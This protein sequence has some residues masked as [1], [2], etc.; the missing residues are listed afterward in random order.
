MAAC[1]R[2]VEETQVSI[3]VATFVGEKG[4]QKGNLRTSVS[5]VALLVE[6]ADGHLG[7]FGKPVLLLSHGAAG[8]GGCRNQQT[9]VAVSFQPF[10]LA[11]E[12]H[13]SHAWHLATAKWWGQE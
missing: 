11:E 8:D 13:S 12:P 3:G 2:R 6:P 4:R 10:S 7:F 9:R 1:D 5:A